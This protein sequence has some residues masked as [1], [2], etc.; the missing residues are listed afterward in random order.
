[1]AQV[2]AITLDIRKRN[3]SEARSS[4]RHLSGAELFSLENLLSGRIDPL[5]CSSSSFVKR[6]NSQEF[7]APSLFVPYLDPLAGISHWLN[8]T[9]L[10]ESQVINADIVQLPPIVLGMLL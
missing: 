5:S 9:G 2:E 7:L 3:L 1:M 4:S 10:V 8:Q 6:N